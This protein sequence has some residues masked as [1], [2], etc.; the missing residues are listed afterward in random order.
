MESL[1]TKDLPYGR[2]LKKKVEE[3]CVKERLV[4]NGT[5]FIFILQ[6]VQ[7]GCLLLV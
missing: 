6:C 2:T 4:L 1:A 5:V 7:F 3:S